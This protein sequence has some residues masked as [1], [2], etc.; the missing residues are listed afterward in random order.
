MWY[1]TSIIGYLRSNRY[2][3]I[4]RLCSQSYEQVLT[5]IY[6]KKPTGNIN[7]TNRIEYCQFIGQPNI[8]LIQQCSQQ[9]N[10]VIKAKNKNFKHLFLKRDRASLTV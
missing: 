1:K 5:K 4:C 10:T 7:I 9:I 8:S 2:D 6:F 3:I